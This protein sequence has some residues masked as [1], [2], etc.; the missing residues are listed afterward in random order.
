VIDFSLCFKPLPSLVFDADGVAHFTYGA[1]VPD[2]PAESDSN[3]AANTRFVKAARLPAILPAVFDAPVATDQRWLVVPFAGTVTEVTML[4]DA[5][6][7]VAFSVFKAAFADYPTGTLAETFL[8][9][10]SNKNQ[11]TSAIEVAAGDILIVEL[12]SATA[13]DQFAAYLKVQP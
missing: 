5:V 11:V 12:D 8:L 13:L 1:A 2:A 9:D 10:D 4:A 3:V 6:G 7:T